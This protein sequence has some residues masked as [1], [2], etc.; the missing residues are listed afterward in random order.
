MAK[1]PVSDLLQ[2]EWRDIPIDVD[3]E[4]NEPCRI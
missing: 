2:A 1:A 3:Q 4:R